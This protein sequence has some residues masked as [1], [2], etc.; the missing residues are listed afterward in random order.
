MV[1]KFLIR[2]SCA[3][4]N[5]HHD[6]DNQGP[7]D[8]AN[9]SVVQWCNASATSNGT[10]GSALGGPSCFV[11]QSLAEYH[12]KDISLK[13]R[14]RKKDRRRQR[15]D[16][17]G[18]EDETTTTCVRAQVWDI[19]VPQAA[20]HINKNNSNDPTSSQDYI[21]SCYSSNYSV[22]SKSSIM[23]YPYPQDHLKNNHIN[24]CLD[25]NKLVTS[26]LPLLKRING[27]IIA[28]QCPLPP[29]SSSI[30]PSSN[31]SHA[32][33][34]SSSIQSTSN[35]RSNAG[36]WAEL[37]LLEKHIAS[38][39]D[40]INTNLNS[41]GA[42]KFGSGSSGY[43]NSSPYTIFVILTFADWAITEYSPKEWMRLSVKMEEIC[44]KFKIH[45]WR[46]GTSVSSSGGGD[47]GSSGGSCENNDR[48][49]IGNVE[50]HMDD[51]KLA[52]TEQKITKETILLSKRQQRQH[53]GLFQRMARQQ[54]DM[55]EE[56]EDSVEAAFIDMILLHLDSDSTLK[57]NM[58][59][60]A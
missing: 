49:G 29:S 52:E 14:S 21:T 47:G 28:C 34:N 57:N 7:F 22:S 9:G 11:E 44:T 30:L 39:M 38:W 55:M 59:K 56:M 13:R 16:N 17:N 36:E 41:N 53:H 58:G 35:I 43:N 25:T 15:D 50:K 40:F 33:Y 19:N 54:Q 51:E 42:K 48:S 31:V 60:Q 3:S 4:N 20:I 18:D 27:I 32:S 26:L 1:A 45:S 2:K 6:N 37:D 12:K 10:F 5:N 23:T 8:G 46:M 24:N